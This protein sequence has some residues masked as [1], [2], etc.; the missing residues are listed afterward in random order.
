[1]VVT[2]ISPSYEFFLYYFTLVTTPMFLFCGVFYPVD[3]LPLIVQSVV[4]V[5][6]LTHVVEVVRPLAIGAPVE[7]L[8]LHLGILVLY[9]SVAFGLATRLIE[10]RLIV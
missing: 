4:A 3:S 9:A 1:M 10:R 5:L 7:H 6:P 8:G 2:A